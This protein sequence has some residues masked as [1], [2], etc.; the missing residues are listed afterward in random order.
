[1]NEIIVQKIQNL[2]NHKM[3]FKFHVYCL[4]IMHFITLGARILYSEDVIKNE[5]L[6]IN[7]L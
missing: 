3:A 5:K 1:M 4:K 7:K 2:T 6:T